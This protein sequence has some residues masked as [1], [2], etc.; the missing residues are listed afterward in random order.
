M[1]NNH[2]I[3]HI[4][5][6][7]SAFDVRIFH[8]ECKTLAN[9]GFDVS[10]II[11]YNK[12][13]TVDGVTLY[14][15]KNTTG[16]L[17]RVTIKQFYA[18][19]EAIKIDA[20]IYHLHDPELIFLGILLKLNGKKVIYDSHEDLP[21]QIL[22]KPYINDFLKP[23]ISKVVELTEDSLIRYFDAVITVTDDIERRFKKINKNTV[24]IRNYPLLEENTIPYNFSKKENEICYVGGVSEYR[25]IYELIESLNYSKIK[26]NL[27]GNFEDKN[28]EK[29]CK[30]S[31]GWKYVNYYGFVSRKEIVNILNK[32]SIGIV[33]L[34]PLVNYLDSL[35]IKM[36]EYMAAGLPVIAS[37]FPK[38]REIIE[39]NNCGI[40]VDPKDPIAIA[41]AINY[42]TD[43]KDIAMKL[44][45]NGRKA[46]LSKYNWDI[47]SKKL[48]NLYEDLLKG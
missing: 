14:P 39:S 47:E 1:R 19:R 9:N 6:V 41:N 15:I 18:F 35:P 48:I 12:N 24:D 33:T 26:L 3:C 45:E 29:K 40:L 21:R 20:D 32:S 43:N 2:K 46:V 31:E 5:T 22:S 36:F 44:G 8:K 4:S 38:W 7:H 11:T 37:D 28:F 42:L 16:R 10:L 34:H 27:A 25:G 13:E 17:R 30:Q 23:V